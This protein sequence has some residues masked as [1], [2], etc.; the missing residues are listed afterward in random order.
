MNFLK[1]WLLREVWPVIARRFFHLREIERF[2]EM[3]GER[4]LDTA[5]WAGMRGISE[6]EAER[7]L[8]YG[9]QSGILQRCFLYEWPDSPVQFIV[10]PEYVGRKV[11]LRDIGYIGE[12]DGR[13]IAVSE[14]RVREIF[15]AAGAN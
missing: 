10:P 9:V 14:F 7:Q 5:R 11:K 1:S 3:T 6:I 4:Y 15:I 13:V 12:D 2:I 8:E